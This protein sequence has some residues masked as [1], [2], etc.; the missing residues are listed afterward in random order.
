MRGGLA[1]RRTVIVGGLALAASAALAEDITTIQTADGRSLRVWIWP[2]VGPQRGVIAF[3]HGA[4]S[5]PVKYMRLVEPWTR[6]GFKV[7]APL[8]V[9]STDNPDHA[10][11]GMIESWRCRI[12][13]MRAVADQAAVP[14]YIAAGHSY[15]ALTALTLGGAEATIPGGVSGPLRDPR[16]E[17]VV[18]FSPPGAS[19][20]LITAEGYS[21]LA[22]PALI[23]TGTADNPP[24]A[25]GGGDWRN[26]LT[27]YEAASPGDKYA[28]VLDGADHYFGGLICRPELP[29]PPQTA[30]L[31]K[32]TARSIDFMAAYAA[33]DPAARRPLELA[34][35][36]NDRFDVSR[37]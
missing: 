24:A 12:L 18:A 33:H 8:H 26:H 27:A 1:T 14:R 28:I 7:L 17:I 5:S 16:A 34:V 10:R 37:K 3:S 9:D 13:D 21:H 35:R 6:A 30:A 2:A 20:G 4:L 15:G 11:Y 23:E 36:A 32:A 25:M 19:P 22:V 31:A 29:G